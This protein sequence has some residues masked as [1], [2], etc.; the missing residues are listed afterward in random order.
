CPCTS[1]SPSR[2]GS[3]LIRTQRQQNA[4][5]VGN[6][7]VKAQRRVI[8]SR[9]DSAGRSTPVWHGNVLISESGDSAQPFIA[10][11]STGCPECHDYVAQAGRGRSGETIRLEGWC[12]KHGLV[13]RAYKLP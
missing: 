8:M 4:D 11:T 6:P 12:P 3:R 10:F 9:S 1:C 7:K 2:G 5:S 13:D